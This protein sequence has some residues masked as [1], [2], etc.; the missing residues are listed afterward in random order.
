MPTCAW[1]RYGPQYCLLILLRSNT[2]A[3]LKQEN[4]IQIPYEFKIADQEPL[5]IPGL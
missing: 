4:K 2:N 5:E 3:K 1:K